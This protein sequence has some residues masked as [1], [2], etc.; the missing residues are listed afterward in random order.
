MAFTILSDKQVN[1][2]L[3]SLT[4]DELSEFRIA[5]S[6][7]LHEFSNSTTADDGDVYQQPHRI[8]TYHS[9]T[10]ATTLYM[11][12]SGPEG[13]GCKGKLPYPHAGTLDLVLTLVRS[14]IVDYVGGDAEP[15]RQTN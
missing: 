10:A 11:P 13:M 4:V 3:E 8:T 7:A 6:A 12:S 9:G 14:R 5:L 1:Q 2:V 15:R